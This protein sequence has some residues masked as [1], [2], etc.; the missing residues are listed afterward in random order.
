VAFCEP[1]TIFVVNQLAV[2]ECGSRLAESS[3]KQN[4]A[5]CGFEQIRP[6]DHFRDA[7]SGVVNHY[8]ELIRGDIVAPPDHEIAEVFSGFVHL[9]AKPQIGESNQFAIGNTEPPVDA[10]R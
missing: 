6:T 3:V 10:N 7:H 1:L 4:L 9:P 2:M 8:S 5:R